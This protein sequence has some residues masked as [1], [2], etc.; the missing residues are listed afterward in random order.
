MFILL[1]LKYIIENTYRGNLVIYFGIYTR[2][3]T[4][5]LIEFD[6][7]Y[8]AKKLVFAVFDLPLGLIWKG[9]GLSSFSV[10]MVQTVHLACATGRAVQLSGPIFSLFWT[11]GCLLSPPTKN[12]SG[13][14]CVL[15]PTAAIPPYIVVAQFTHITV[16]SSVAFLTRHLRQAPSFCA[17]ILSPTSP[18]RP[19]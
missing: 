4:K 15:A 3:T 1:L 12:H 19:R 16:W 10:N 7:Q 14:T 9:G 2:V 6:R 8:I 18:S 5:V 11:H 17:R 13:N